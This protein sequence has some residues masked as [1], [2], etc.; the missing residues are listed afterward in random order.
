[1]S[2]SFVITPQIKADLREVGL[3]DEQIDVLTSAEAEEIIA[4]TSVVVTNGQ[5]VREFIEIIVAQARAA[6]KEIKDPG[7]LQLIR[8]HPLAKNYDDVVIYRYELN[9][10]KL[11]ERMTKD[12]VDAS[13]TGHNIYVETRTVRRGLRAWQRG[14]KEDTVAVFALAV[15]S[16]SD[17][18][19]AWM[20]TVPV[21]L[22]VETSPD[23]AHFWFF[24]EPAIDWKTADKLGERL[25]KATG[26]DH[27][28]GVI[29]QPYRVAG[30]RNYPNKSKQERGRTEIV[31]TSVRGFDPGSLWTPER[32]DQEFPPEP[33]VNGGGQTNGAAASTASATDESSI[34]ADTL[35]VIREGVEDDEDRSDAFWNVMMVLKE[36]GWTLAGIITLLDRYPKGIAEKYRGR[37]QREV[38]RIWNKLARAPS[39]ARQQQGPSPAVAPPPSQP[40]PQ[41]PSQP[42][43]QPP[44]AGPGVGPTPSGPQPR[45]RGLEDR[46]ALKLA[47]QHADNLRYI[48]KSSQWMQWGETCWQS[49]DT[50]TAFDQ[51]RVLCRAA[52]DARAKTVAAVVTLARADRRLA[53]TIG[54]WD[55]HPMLFNTTRGTIDLTTGIERAPERGDY[56]TKRASTWLAD[57]GTPHPLWTSFLNDVTKADKTNA[58]TELIGFLQRLSGYCLTGLTRE[59]VLAFL[60]GP[61]GNGKG[62]F[63][64]TLTKIM[65]DY[66]IIAPIEMFLASKYQN[67]P[68]EIARLKGA[69]LVLAQ[70]TQKGGRWDEPKLKALTGGDRLT[71][72][73]MRQDFFDF[74]PT[75]KIIILGNHKPGLS[76]VNEAIRRRLLL[77]LFNVV[78]PPAKRDPD[79]PNKLVPEHPAILRWMLDGC[80]EWQRN[81]L[82]VPK[83][84]QEASKQYFANQDTMEQWFDDCVDTTDPRA[85]TASRALYSSWRRWCDM[86]GMQP[87]TEKDFVEELA[88]KGYNQHRYSSARG[89]KGLKL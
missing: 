27:N 45:G 35:H 67:H 85:F 15:D 57:K 84:V 23:N 82:M 26:G 7:V 37:L 39:R 74:D 20:P 44:G 41:P 33:K 73:F 64:G 55:T 56:M 58:D 11:I 75:H 78:I 9:D 32:F 68:T 34:P 13:E 12:A 25:R 31:P 3:S 72:H 1:M 18:G 16:D 88:D 61:G 21:S 22:A 83:S 47:A 5:E 87:G 70:E 10:S 80:L 66:A 50:L 24:F 36:D 8:A 2:D 76:A 19:K 69:R 60:F 28:T 77:T 17:K 53:A 49:E 59:Q 65:G 30:T 79:L 4:A 40:P 38:E 46:V 89:F 62:V 14:K 54:Q 42:P 52:G 63:G 6:T 86:R 43:P 81:G 29:T 71:G 51:S 48:A